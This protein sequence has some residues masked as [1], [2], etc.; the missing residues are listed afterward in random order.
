M[1][2]VLPFSVECALR[3]SSQLNLKTD[4]DV[5]LQHYHLAVESGCLFEFARAHTHRVL[6]SPHA[7]VHYH[8]R[9]RSSTE[10][11][12]ADRISSQTSAEALKHTIAVS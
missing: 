11:I 5:K 7:Q 10:Q 3:Q 8:Q 6:N 2:T 12:A 1:I 4:E 9:H